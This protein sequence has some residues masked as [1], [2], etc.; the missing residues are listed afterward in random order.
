MRI[1]FVASANSIH[2]H[3]WIKFFARKGHEVH[4]ISPDPL[5]FDPLPGVAY[6]ELPRPG[7]PVI[8]LLDSIRRTRSIVRRVIPDIVHAH[9]AGTCGLLGALSGCSSFMLTAWGSDIYLAPRSVLRRPLIKLALKR[10]K[11][12]TCGAEHMVKAIADL[13]VDA[14]KIRIVL[15]GIDVETFSPHDRSD[16]FARRFGIAGSPVVISLRHLDPV[17]DVASL[18]RA[19]PL[20]LDKVPDAKFVI[21]G[22]GTEEQR[23][24]DLAGSLG[25]GGSVLFIGKYSY[26]VLPEYLHASDVYVSTSLQDGGFAASTS[27]AMACGVPAIVTD[28][29][30]NRSW[31]TDG[32]DGFVVPQSSPS[33]LAE[34]ITLLLRDEPLRKRIGSRG[35]ELIVHRN[36]LYREMENM[37]K[38]YQDFFK[39]ERPMEERA[40]AFSG[41][42]R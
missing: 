27:E 15:F 20:V 13:G 36:N 26:D 12:I 35:R 16:I 33:G 31:I 38:I 40:S 39:H 4:W 22:S 34:R 11:L 29:G 25:V 32:K 2:S 10:A 41:R 5:I 21:A 42:S 14:R 30:A 18:V 1:C 19:V 6:Y 7:M 3:K 17:Y 24:K 23:L 28:F 37:E 8:S 9:Y